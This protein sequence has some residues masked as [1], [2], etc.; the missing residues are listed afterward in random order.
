[1]Y[2][3]DLEPSDDTVFASINHALAGSQ[4]GPI[5]VLEKSENSLKNP[6]PQMTSSFSE[7]VIIK[8][9]RY[10]RNM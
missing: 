1:M 8:F 5:A 2:F 6:L 7:K 3:P 9:L 10:G 4:E